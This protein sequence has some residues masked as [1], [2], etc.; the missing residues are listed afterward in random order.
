MSITVEFFGIARQRAGTATVQ[1]QAASVRQ[2]IVELDAKYPA[3]R[4]VCWDSNGLL[5][6][7]IANR[8][9]ERF[10]SDL[11]TPLAPGD[12]LLILSTDAGG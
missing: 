9:G 7:Y 5:P 3:L 10:I 8:G 4:G 12:S 6:G 11:D 1:V 2:A